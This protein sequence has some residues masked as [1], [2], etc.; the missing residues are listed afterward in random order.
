MTQESDRFERQIHRIHELVEGPDTTVRWNDR[1]PDPD[2]PQQARQID[3]TIKKDGSLTLVECRFREA[4]QNVNWIEELIGRRKSLQADAV[5]A[6]SVSGFTE[7]AVI[8]AKKFGIVLRDVASLT[9]EEISKWGNKTEIS[10]DYV[11]PTKFALHFTLSTGRNKSRSLKQIESC[12]RRKQQELIALSQALLHEVAKSLQR[13]GDA[14]ISARTDLDT[15]SLGFNQYGVS[16]C[17]LRVKAYMR[18]ESISTV[19]VVG[20]DQPGTESL[21][22]NN[23]AQIVESGDFQISHSNGQVGYTI[24][25]SG[26]IHPNDYLFVSIGGVH[27]R[28]VSFGNLVVLDNNLES[29]CKYSFDAVVE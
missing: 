19:G 29:N 1:I 22:R 9:E 24:D 20:Y 6:V 11:G 18:T 25:L 16:K 17:E 15:L 7:G 12:I 23:Y 28:D 21:Y 8:K 4:V 5:I 13:T 10:L 26:I 27:E 14:S 2:N 3:V